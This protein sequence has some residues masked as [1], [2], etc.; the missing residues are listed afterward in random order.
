MLHIWTHCF[1]YLV[2]LDALHSAQGLD[3][4]A[5]TP[6]YIRNWRNKADALYT[7][8][9]CI[10]CCDD[11]V[12]LLFWGEADALPRVELTSWD[13]CDWRRPQGSGV[14]SPPGEA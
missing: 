7:C 3:V 9:G 12:A 4:L 1:L 11:I 14:A 6:W 10:G 13:R 2:A 5:L 8:P